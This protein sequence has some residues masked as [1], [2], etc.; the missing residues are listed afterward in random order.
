MRFV[1]VGEPVVKRPIMVAA[2]QDMGNVGNICIDFLN[3]TL[4]TKCFRQVLPPLPNYVIDMGGFIEYRKTVWEYCYTDGLI[5]FGGGSGQPQTDQELYD[6]CNDVVTIA[7]K[8]SAQMIYAL[9]AFH[10]D[11]DFGNAPKTFAAA[12]D[13]GLISKIDAL[14]VQRTPGSSLI[15]GFN[16]LILGIAKESEIPAVGL[17]SEIDDPTSP[18]YRSAKALLTVLGKLMY[19]SFKG[20]EGLEEFAKAIDKDKGK[21]DSA[22]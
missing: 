9:G 18:Q 12:T 6:L 16:G 10:T 8:Y 13:S 22:S 4:S 11:R 21:H 7:K 17:Y 14:G 3:H 2:M 1:D 5:I 15:T 20:L 19:Q